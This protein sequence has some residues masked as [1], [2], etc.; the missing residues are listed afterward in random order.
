MKIFLLQ[1]ER[2]WLGANRAAIQGGTISVKSVV[3]AATAHGAGLPVPPLTAGQAASVFGLGFLLALNDYL[4]RNP[5]PDLPVEAI[6]KV[7]DKV[8]DKVPLNP[9][10]TDH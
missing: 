3:A 1:L 4:A 5:L 10:T 9:V 7:Q 8:Q 6:D 2:W